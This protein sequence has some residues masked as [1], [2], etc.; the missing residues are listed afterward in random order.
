MEHHLLVTSTQDWRAR[1]RDATHA[2]LYDAAMQLF[3]ERGYDA[4][5]V[6]EIA[7]AA[8][9]SVPTFYADYASKEHI[10]MPIPDQAEIN[11]VL[12]SMPQE[13]ALPDRVRSGM[14]AWLAQYGPE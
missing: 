2:R 12:E 13:L 5:S 8:K 11:A 10:V 1:T 14:L 9:V 6:G 3:G 4:V 7:A